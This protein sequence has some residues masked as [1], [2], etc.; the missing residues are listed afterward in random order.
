MRKESMS[1]SSTEVLKITTKAARE[2]TSGN[3]LSEICDH[4]KNPGHFL[5]K[6]S[7]SS[8]HNFLRVL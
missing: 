2:G 7:C 1:I 4:K 5:G 6:L 3:E 8:A